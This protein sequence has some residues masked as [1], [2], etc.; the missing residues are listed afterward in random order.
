MK[1]QNQQFPCWCIQFENEIVNPKEFIESFINLRPNSN[2]VILGEGVAA[3]E[4]QLWSAW[5]SLGRR[6]KNGSMLSKKADVEFLRLIA[7]THQISIALERT[8]VRVSDKIA[9]IVYLPKWSDQHL[10]SPTLT[11]I[12]WNLREKE[13]QKMMLQLNCKP[14]QLRPHPTDLGIERLGL[15]I[16]KSLTVEEIEMRFLSHVACSDLNLN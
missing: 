3:S 10:L 7:G 2:W 8:G 9:W 4:K 16:Q 13:I 15:N 12:D 6:I 5:I 1:L 14:K 11:E